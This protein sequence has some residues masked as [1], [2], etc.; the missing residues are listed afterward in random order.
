MTIESSASERQRR[1]RN[2]IVLG[3]VLCVGWLM[4]GGAGLEFRS[5]RMLWDGQAS[6]L[7]A[8]VSTLPGLAGVMVIILAM[9]RYSRMRGVM[10]IALPLITVS[11]AAVAV[12]GRHEGMKGALDGPGNSV[13]L[14]VLLLLFSGAFILTGIR[15]ESY[16]TDL[17]FGAPLAVLGA[18]MY[19]A[20]VAISL[21]P[22]Q[23]SGGAYLGQLFKMTSAENPAVRVIGICITLEMCLMVWTCFC[24]A[25]MLRSRRAPGDPEPYHWWKMGFWSWVSARAFSVL[26]IWNIAKFYNRDSDIILTMNLGKDLLTGGATGLLFF[27]GI[28]DLIIGPEPQYAK[29]RPAL[30]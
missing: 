2:L 16:R 21:I 9:V 10:M 5:I 1:R 25:M 15:V 22:W 12:L 23:T 24:S 19:M 20:A 3:V 6:S 13:V 7:D 4:P 17:K 14:M 27:A 11:L 30:Q 18:A 26:A 28:V 8:V 29:N